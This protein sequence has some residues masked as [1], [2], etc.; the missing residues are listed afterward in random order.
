LTFGL[1]RLELIVR[2]EKQVLLR[3]GILESDR[4]REPTLHLD[5]SYQ[6]QS[7]E[8]IDMALG[9]TEIDGS[10]RRSRAAET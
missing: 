5:E 7:R 4:L 3:R 6:Q 2:M 8:L 1:Q 9:L 10:A